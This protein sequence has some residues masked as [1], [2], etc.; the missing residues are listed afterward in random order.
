MARYNLTTVPVVDARGILLGQI[1]FDDVIDVV[2]AEQT[3]DILKFAGASSDEE[4]GGGWFEAVKS[5]LPWLYLNLLTAFLAGGVVFLFQSTISRMV[6]LAA[7]AGAG[8]HGAA[9]ALQHA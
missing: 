6:A 9:L 1:T 7:A 2:E 3:E 8:E 4:L 5:R